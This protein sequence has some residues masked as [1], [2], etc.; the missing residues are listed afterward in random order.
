MILNFFALCYFIL[1]QPILPHFTISFLKN[2]N[3]LK[4]FRLFSVCSVHNIPV[5]V[6]DLD[7][8][9]MMNFDWQ[10]PALV[11]NP[12]PNIQ[13]LNDHLSGQFHNFLRLSDTLC[14]S[15]RVCVCMC[16]NVSRACLVICVATT[17]SAQ[18][19]GVASASCCHLGVFEW[20]R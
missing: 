14:V 9:W 5:V 10:L 8:H 3:S 6:L 18:V 16:V 13:A 7:C 2:K 15:V 1:F 12:C 20:S 4:H 17:P 19:G 11:K